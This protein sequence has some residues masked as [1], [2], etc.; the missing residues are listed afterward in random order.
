ML[1]EFR[2]ANYGCFKD[3]QTLSF[4]ASNDQSLEDNVISTGGFRVLRSAILYGANASGKS[5]LVRVIN[6]ICG[7]VL[8]SASLKPDDTTPAVP[9]LLDDTSRNEPS[10]FELTFVANGIRHQFGFTATPERICDEW[11]IVYPKG[12]AQTWYERRYDKETNKTTWSYSSFLLGE[13]QRIA[14]RTRANALFLSVAA[15]WDNEQLRGVYDWFKNGIV[16]I[17][18]KG[19]RPGLTASMFMESEEGFGHTV[20]E[21][22]EGFLTRADLGIQGV[23]V[24]ERRLDPGSIRFPDEMP[25]SERKKFVEEWEQKYSS[26][27]S[28]LH[29]NSQSN[30][31]IEFDFDVESNGTKRAFDLLGPWILALGTGATL[32]VDELET[33]LHPLLARELIQVF[34]SKEAAARQPQLL[35]ATHDTTLL[36]P[37]LFRR[38]QVWFTEKDDFGAAVLYSLAEHRER[39]ARKGEAMQKRY[40]AG[41]YGGIPVI[42]ERFQGD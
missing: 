3:E 15:Q 2:V 32:V 26:R 29:K 20:K 38:D 22:V 1:L 12:R 36:D 33:S 28:M 21:F 16:F 4:V 10:F 30:E 39:K 5:T 6:L 27:V 23:L 19:P 42:A 18:E 31:P 35:V 40:L 7:G 17:G 41:L 34:L 8:D 25:E 9:F 11:L 24:K 13:K 14:D 37:S